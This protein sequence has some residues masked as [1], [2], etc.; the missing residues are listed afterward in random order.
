[1]SCGDC[2]GNTLNLYD[3]GSVI[4]GEEFVTPREHSTDLFSSSQNLSVPRTKH[5]PKTWSLH[6]LYTQSVTVGDPAFVDSSPSSWSWKF[7]MGLICR[8]DAATSRLTV[9]Q[10][11]QSA[12]PHQPSLNI[13]SIQVPR[14]PWHTPWRLRRA[15]Q[16]PLPGTTGLETGRQIS[17]CV[18]TAHVHWKPTAWKQYFLCDWGQK[19]YTHERKVEIVGH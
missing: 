16:D 19:K 1:M 7:C 13:F 9:T 17:W 12:L 6:S 15:G 10:W 2:A 14:L 11:S 8:G 5:K 4:S 3:S 18:K